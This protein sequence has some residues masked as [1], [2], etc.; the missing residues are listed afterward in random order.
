[1]V[2]CFG[3]FTYV[4]FLLYHCPRQSIVTRTTDRTTIHTFITLRNIICKLYFIRLSSSN[5]SH[6]F[7]VQKVEIRK[8][9]CIDR[10][11]K[12]HLF[13]INMQKI[14]RLPCNSIISI[15]V[16]FA[17]RFKYVQNSLNLL[18]LNHNLFLII[19]YFNILFFK[20]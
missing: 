19:S 16:Y 1:M 18:L 14:N 10:K 5:L 9:Y 7:K 3:L 8:F 13:W 4:V 6:C 2:P 17:T 11:L 12:N 20:N 15:E